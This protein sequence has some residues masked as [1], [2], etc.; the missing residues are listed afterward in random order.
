MRLER[1][2]EFEATDIKPSLATGG[3]TGVL[4]LVTDQGRVS[5][6]LRRSVLRRL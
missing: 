5:I 1:I 3:A 2:Q 4:T 6:H